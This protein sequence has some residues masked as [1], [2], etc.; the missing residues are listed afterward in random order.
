M[1]AKSRRGSLGRFRLIFLGLGLLAKGPV[2]LVFFTRLSCVFWR[3]RKLRRFV[4][5]AH[6]VGLV[7]MLGI[8][9]AWA[10]PFRRL[11]AGRALRTSGRDNS[12]AGL[13]GEDFKFRRLDPEHS[14]R[15]RLFSAVGFAF[16]FCSLRRICGGNRP[17][18]ARLGA[19]GSRFRS[20]SISLIPGR[21]RATRCRCSRPIG[22]S[23]PRQLCA[24][25][26]DLATLARRR[27]PAFVRP[28]TGPFVVAIVAV[29]SV[30][31]TRSLSF[32]VCNRGRK[33]KTIASADRSSVPAGEP[34]YAVDPDYQPFLFY[35]RRPLFTSTAS[36]TCRP[37][38]TIFWCDPRTKGR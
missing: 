36:M 34:L 8:F 29:A 26:F 28:T 30:A 19:G 5:P 21:S 22:G 35:V 9:A 25:R 10:I 3:T 6:L 31:V 13:T 23:W 11:P 24:E 37:R 17:G 20:S 2:H 14:A 1:G 27:N 12:P 18:C 32:R 33:S 16:A 4:T 15:S 38:R 7:M